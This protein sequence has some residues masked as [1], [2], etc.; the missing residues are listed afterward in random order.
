MLLLIFR[1][2]EDLKRTTS[3]LNEM[4][5]RTEEMADDLHETREELRETRSE[6]DG[7]TIELSTTKNKLQKTQH[8]L[9]ECTC[10]SCCWLPF[11]FLISLSFDSHH[12]YFPCL[13]PASVSFLLIVLPSLFPLCFPSLCSGTND[14]EGVTTDVTELE[15]EREEK[16]IELSNVSNELE[17]LREHAA[18]LESNVE[19]LSQTNDSLRLDVEQ[20]REDATSL[21]R[22]ESVLICFFLF[23]FFFPFL[24]HAMSF[25]PS[26]KKRKEE[27]CFLFLCVPS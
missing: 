7:T 24:L 9:V 4:T 26:I 18:E 21:Q 2:D 1:L 19:L 10:S 5:Q 11:C 20:S 15:R 14:F 16:R 23:F 17:R 27:T 22:G 8:S 25:S 3:D 6:L 13:S 12:H